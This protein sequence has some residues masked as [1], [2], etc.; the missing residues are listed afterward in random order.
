[1][2]GQCSEDEKESRYEEHAYLRTS[3]KLEDKT[4]TC[5]CCYLRKA[6]STVEEAEICSDVAA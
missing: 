3:Y 6:Y 2:Y 4:S 5:S 1:M